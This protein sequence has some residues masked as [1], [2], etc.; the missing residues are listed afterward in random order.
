MD[1]LIVDDNAEVSAAYGQVLKRAGYMVNA[2]DNGLA[3]PMRGPV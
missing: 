3:A 1:V 2:V